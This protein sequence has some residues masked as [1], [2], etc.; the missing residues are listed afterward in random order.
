MVKSQAKICKEQTEWSREYARGFP[1]DF[2]GRGEE[3]LYAY[4]LKS[5]DMPESLSSYHN[6]H[7]TNDFA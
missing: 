4:Y 7:M 5:V 1:F 6:R 2:F 3:V